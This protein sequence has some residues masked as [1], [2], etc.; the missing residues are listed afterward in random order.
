MREKT[1]M[2]RRGEAS[3]EAGETSELKTLAESI[4]HLTEK[5]KSKPKQLMLLFCIFKRHLL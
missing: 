1:L 2:T 5:G 3:L 4:A